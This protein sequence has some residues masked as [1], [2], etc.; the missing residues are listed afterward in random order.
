MANN[1]L[2]IRP[3]ETESD[4]LFNALGVT[5]ERKDELGKACMIAL[6]STNKV[7]DALEQISTQVKH[8][9][10]LALAVMM[11]NDLRQAMQD[12]MT[13]IKMMMDGEGGLPGM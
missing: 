9:N 13:F 2:V 6:Q 11:L 7:S 5:P 12:P 8:A 10:E 4:D 3:I 1:D